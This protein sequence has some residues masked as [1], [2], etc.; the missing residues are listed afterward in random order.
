MS[1]LLLHLQRAHHACVRRRERF[2]LIGWVTN[3]AYSP[4]SVVLHVQ[5]VVLDQCRT[6]VPSTLTRGMRIRSHLREIGETAGRPG[7]RGSRACWE[8]LRTCNFRQ[9]WAAR[10]YWVTRRMVGLS[11]RLVHADLPPMG[12]SSHRLKRELWSQNVSSLFFGMNSAQTGG[13]VWYELFYPFGK[14]NSPLNM[15]LSPSTDPRQEGIVWYAKLL[16]VRV[17]NEG[18]AGSV[19]VSPPVFLRILKEGAVSDSP[20][21]STRARWPGRKAGR[22]ARSAPQYTGQRR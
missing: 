19:M 15:S 1:T 5:H 13:R 2:R 10:R 8:P 3:E 7:R 20:S 22:Q 18:S 17:L 6:T 12:V 21:G 4:R 9:G 11:R 14:P 16:F